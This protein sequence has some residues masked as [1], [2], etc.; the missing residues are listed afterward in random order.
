MN[1]STAITRA[2]AHLLKSE[3]ARTYTAETW[4]EKKRYVLDMEL[5]VEETELV[6]TNPI[7]RLR[8][9]PIPQTRPELIKAKCM[10]QTE[11]FRDGVED[12]LLRYYLDILRRESYG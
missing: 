11:Q 9:I 8:F 1:L 3:K 5:S 2:T 6:V 10:L 7:G 4:R 12:V